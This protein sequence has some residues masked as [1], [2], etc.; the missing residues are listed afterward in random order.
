MKWFLLL[1]LIPAVSNAFTLT[2]NNRAY[3]GGGGAIQ[4]QLDAL[5]DAIQSQFNTS[6]A[7]ANN[8]SEFLTQA[9]NANAMSSRSFLSPG[10]L[11]RTD[12]YLFGF[13]GS[14]ALAL[15]SGASLSNGISLPQNQ[16]PPLGVG[17][18][19]GFTLGIPAKNL[20]LPLRLDPS[21]LM[22]SASFYSM[23]LS[24]VI[25]HGVS[26]NSMQSSLGL[27]YQF[28][29]PQ[30]WTPLIRF[31]GFRISSGLSYST[32]DATYS[33]PFN[34][35]QSGGGVNMN[36]NSNV[37]IGVSSSVFSLTN[38]VSTGFR[39]L[40]LLNLY[41]GLGVDFNFGS[42]KLTGGSTGPVV[43]TQGAST[44]FTGTATVDGAS[45]GTTPTLAQVRYLVGTE[46]DLGPVGIY[47]QGQVS[48]PS[49]YGLNLGAHFLF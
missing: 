43:G 16:L 31:N 22:I 14:M 17:A 48:T 37:D 13:G 8:Q 3:P 47:L 25:G 21:R 15:G 23:D 7:S 4:A 19:T 2:I 40:G 11:T 36:W 27:S 29:S 1:L 44:V 24:S 35:T 34:L 30:S 28:Y 20:K 12:Q 49:V 9:G 39:L 41:T 6:I 10:A 42:S 26:L 46:F 38:E 45:S 5:A 33:T 32:F 18:K